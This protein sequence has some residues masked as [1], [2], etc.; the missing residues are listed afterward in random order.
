VT[1]DSGAIGAACEVMGIA[2]KI[3]AAAMAIAGKVARV[4]VFS[5]SVQ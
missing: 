4:I 1:P 3:K 5:L 2:P